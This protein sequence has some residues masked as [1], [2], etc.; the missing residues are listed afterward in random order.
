M[1]THHVK[2]GR[3]DHGAQACDEVERLEDEC[4]GAVAPCLFHDVA[5]ASV[6]EPFES[7]GGD[8]RSAEAPLL[9]LRLTAHRV[10]DSLD[11]F[12]V[13]TVDGDFGMNVE[14]HDCGGRRGGASARRIDEPQG[15]LSGACAGYAPAPW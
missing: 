15:G 1:V 2:A 6:I 9:A 7:V 14:A 3:R 8:G 4:V 11:P 13:P 5:Q 12:S 10:A